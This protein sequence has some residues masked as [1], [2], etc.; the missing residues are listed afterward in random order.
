MFL[1]EVEFKVKGGDGG[2]GVVSF[3]REKYID[4]GGPDGGDGGDGGNV[5]LKVDEGLNTLSDF[6]YQKYREA[7][8]GTHGSGSN[9]HGRNGE[10]LI[11]M[12]PPGTVVYKA[13]S[14]ELMADLTDDGQE[15]IA[16]H[17]GK[18]GKGNARFKKPTR[19]APRFAEQGETGE[20]VNLRLELK[21]LAD[22][23]LLGFPNVGKS[24]LISSVSEAKPKI[25]SYH[26]TTLK[27]NLGVVSIGE[28]HSFVMADIPGLI[29]GAHQGIG[30][31]DEF[32]RHIERT[33]LLIHVIDVSG[34]EGREPVEDFHLINNE[35][36]KYNERLASRPQLVALNKIDIP[37]AEENIVR[38]T[39]ELKKEGYEVYP[40]SA[41]THQGVN[42]LIYRVGEI[43][44]ELPEEELPEIEDGMVMITPDFVEEEGLEIKRLNGDLYQIKGELVDEYVQKTDFNNEDSVKRLL[45]VLH[46]H[47]LGKLMKNAGVQEG[48][49]VQIGPMEFDYIE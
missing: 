36:A 45:R 28:Y 1:D 33:R 25:A 41:V 6:R 32:L 27:P 37:Q 47:G 7:G 48:D 24:T 10:D 49:T 35:L 13:D 11:L 3:R 12:V 2:N 14:G 17:G 38:V 9:K 5:I 15:F 46:H 43:L 8:R 34:I 31:G 16:A 19:K 44:A 39:E 30:L 42:N 20:I 22:V 21:L 4:M 40:I 26:F 23:G 18:G 29:E